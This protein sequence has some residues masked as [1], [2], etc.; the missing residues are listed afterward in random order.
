DQR[1]FAAGVNEDS[2]LQITSDGRYPTEMPTLWRLEPT[3][4]NLKL[5]FAASK[6]QTQITFFPKISRFVPSQFTDCCFQSPA[7]RWL[8]RVAVICFQLFRCFLRRGG[9]RRCFAGR[10][11]VVNPTTYPYCYDEKPNHDNNPLPPCHRLAHGCHLTIGGSGSCP[12][13]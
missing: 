4:H 10:N 1:V 13:A 3:F 7:S 9:R 2:P 5:V 12:T 11:S 8:D 6:C